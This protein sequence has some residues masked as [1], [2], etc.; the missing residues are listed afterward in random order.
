MSIQAT[1]SIGI[2]PPPN[3]GALSDLEGLVLM[4][5]AATP[6]HRAGVLT[7]PSMLAE[8]FLPS[9]GRP[10]VTRLLHKSDRKLDKRG[11]FIVDLHS[12]FVLRFGRF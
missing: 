5:G 4:T 1:S 3:R 6:L 8:P 12:R 10:S 7:S 2:Y 9:V 11:R